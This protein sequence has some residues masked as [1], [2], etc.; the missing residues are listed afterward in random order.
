VAAEDP[1]IGFAR[2]IA[3][4]SPDDW[5]AS[6]AMLEQAVLTCNQA[7]AGAGLDAEALRTL[8]L[9]ETSLLS[10]APWAALLN[11]AW[12]VCDWYAAVRGGRSSTAPAA[13]EEL[14][15]VV[16]RDHE[17]VVE[18]VTAG[19]FELLQSLADGKTLG[20]AVSEALA[21]E[22]GFDLTAE[23]NRMARLGL[24]TA[25]NGRTG[26]DPRAEPFSHVCGRCT[27]CCRDRTVRVDPHEIARLARQLGLSTGAVAVRV[28][29]DGAGA[30]L[31][32]QADGACVFLKDNACSVWP[33]RPLT[34]RLYPLGLV[35]RPDGSEAY[36]RAEAPV[37][38]LGK[39]GDDGTIGEFLEA[40]GADPF[41]A[42]A[43]RYDAWLTRAEARLNIRARAS[44]RPRKTGATEAAA[45]I[46]MD[47]AIARHCRE[48]NRP[49][50]QDL[51]ARLDLHIEILDAA[52]NGASSKAGMA[53]LKAAAAMMANGLGVTDA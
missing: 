13:G 41:I 33:A 31:A 18:R 46:D 20:A 7:P 36:I 22:A 10:L 29:Q 4:T 30:V 40:Q 28:T 52:L 5:I 32:R 16:R 44:S 45:L 17:I 14:I 34:C 39:L 35:L 38:K 53:V 3:E 15:L 23:L 26:P 12:R 11:T 43:K 49:E 2:H 8:D 51:D 27:L 21:V 50:P 47:A 48:A 25:V 37:G 19:A 1:S 24:V 6:V 42:A 9:N